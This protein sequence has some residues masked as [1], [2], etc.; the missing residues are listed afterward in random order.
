MPKNKQYIL[1]QMEECVENTILGTTHFNKNYQ[2]VLKFSYKR[3]RTFSK[4]SK[5]VEYYPLKTT[6][7]CKNGRL[8]CFYNFY[9]VISLPAILPKT[10]ISVIAFPP[11]LLVPCI[12]PT[13]SPAA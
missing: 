1:K 8:C 6:Q 12:P 13:T 7:H 11:N 5:R 4:I 3:Q 2:S 10:I 9:L